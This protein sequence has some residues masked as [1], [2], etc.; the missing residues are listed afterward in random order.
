MTECYC[1]RLRDDKQRFIL[2]LE[3]Q[4]LLKQGQVEIEMTKFVP[5]YR[6]S[7]LLHRSVIEELNGTIKVS[8]LR[9]YQT[10]EYLSIVLVSKIGMTQFILNYI[11][12]I[13]HT[14]ADASNNVHH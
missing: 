14:F 5:D 11:S 12:V 13:L 2:N 7:V 6:T 1:F 4:L 3:V 9:I 8:S 10:A